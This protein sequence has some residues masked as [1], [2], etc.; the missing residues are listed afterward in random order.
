M[1]RVDAI[2]NK[3]VRSVIE[4]HTYTEGKNGG[5]V[6]VVSKLVSVPEHRAHSRMDAPPWPQ[7]GD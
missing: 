6:V 1:Q 5:I 4:C 7:S 2:C 3:R